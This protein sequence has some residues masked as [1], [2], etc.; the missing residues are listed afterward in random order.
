MARHRC[1]DYPE[2]KMDHI[3]V[4][5]LLYASC[6]NHT[7][8]ICMYVQYVYI[9]DV[10]MYVCMYSICCMLIDVISSAPHTIGS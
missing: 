6:D 3:Y 1:W 7:Y 2:F 4:V 5:C 9:R 8:D 10:C